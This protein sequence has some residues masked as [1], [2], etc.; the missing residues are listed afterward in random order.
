LLGLAL[1]AGAM[2]GLA[3]DGGMAKEPVTIRKTKDNLSFQLPPDWPIEKRG[4]VTAPIPVEEYLAMKFKGVEAKLQT[5]EQRLEAMDI[6]LR[7]MEEQLKKQQQS[8]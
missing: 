8:P 5:L 1:V 6:K 2:P 7:L 3:E 4:G